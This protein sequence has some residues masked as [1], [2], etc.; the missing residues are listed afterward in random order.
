MS[1]AKY[2][3]GRLITSLDD[4]DKCQSKFYMVLFGADRK[5]EKTMH[6]G[7]MVGWQ[8]RYVRDMIYDK[9][10][11]EAVRMEGETHEDKLHSDSISK[12]TGKEGDI[13]HYYS[14]NNIS[15][16]CE[17]L[18]L[19]AYSDKKLPRR[20]YIDLAKND[21]MIHLEK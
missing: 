3:R 17:T 21:V 19:L 13:G 5:N 1:K 9:R 10:V 7:Y 12:G 18:R 8:A 16:D 2:K 6:K 20:E 4:F 11:Y 14:R 15:N